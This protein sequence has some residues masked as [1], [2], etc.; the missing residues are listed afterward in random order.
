[1]PSFATDSPLDYKIK[2]GL[3]IDVLKT[4]CL[5]ITRKKQYKS[6]RMNKI[7]ERLLKPQRTMLLDPSKMEE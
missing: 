3:L 2:R 1:M 4:L 5:D 7:Y 6:E